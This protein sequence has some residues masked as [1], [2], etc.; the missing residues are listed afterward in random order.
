ML[1]SEP[2]ADVDIELISWDETEGNL[3]MHT[4][5]GEEGRG[6]IIQSW[7]SKLKAWIEDNYG[8]LLFGVAVGAT[9]TL[10]I[11]VTEETTTI[12]PPDLPDV[13]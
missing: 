3:L 1:T 5:R 4:V 12:Q 9:S 11:T 10:A 6:R 8:V 2:T 7:K 13:P